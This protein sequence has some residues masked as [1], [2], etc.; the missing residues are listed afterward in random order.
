MNDKQK[1][2]ELEEEIIKLKK[3]VTKDELTGALNRK[4]IHD[5]LEAIFK[6]AN[7]LKKHPES[8]REFHIDNLSLIF[9]DIDNFKK[10][11]DIYGHSVGD[12]VLK[13][14]VK[15]INGQVRDM[16]LLGRIG[17][18][19]FIIALIGATE[20]DAFR[21]AE[22]IRNKVAEENIIP[23]IKELNVTASLGVASVM[24][25]NSKTIEDLISMADKAMYEAK[26][27]RGKNNTVKYSEIDG[28]K[29]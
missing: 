12:E 18:E 20:D 5:K 14:F 23:E 21:K 29:I 24:K 22:E 8:K 9:I 28:S 15:L 10:T 6:E 25:T 4:S 3:L 7:F 2:K 1:I 13:S 27:N 11:N 19:E 16:D 26:N 17:G